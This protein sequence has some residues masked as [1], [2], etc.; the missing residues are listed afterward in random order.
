[1]IKIV[2]ECVAFCERLSIPEN[3]IKVPTGQYIERQVKAPQ[4]FDMVTRRRVFL[5]LSIGIQHMSR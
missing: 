4:E 3:Y 1:M 2:K 5:R